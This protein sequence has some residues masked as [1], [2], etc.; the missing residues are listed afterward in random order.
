MNEKHMRTRLVHAGENEL[1]K[2]IASSVSVPKVLPIYMSSVFSF[3]DVPSL[4]A[5][6]AGGC[7][8]LCVLQNDE[9]QH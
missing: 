3:D 2:K 9:P 4:D 6:Y 8:R 5:V 7:L 1:A